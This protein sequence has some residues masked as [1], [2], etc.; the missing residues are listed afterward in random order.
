MYKLMTEKLISSLLYS[1]D[2]YIKR[3]L[4]NKIVNNLSLRSIKEIYC[5]PRLNENEKLKS[6]LIN[7]ALEKFPLNNFGHVEFDK[8]KNKNKTVKADDQKNRINKNNASGVDKQMLIA[9]TLIDNYEISNALTLLKELHQQQP[10]NRKI[11]MKIGEIYQN[12]KNIIPAH[13]FFKAAKTFYPEYGT[14]RKLS[15]EIDNGLFDNADKSIQEILS[16]PKLSLIKFLPVLNRAC[17]YFPHYREEMRRVRTEVKNTLMNVKSRKGI[18]PTDQ[19]KLALKCRWINIAN[20]IVSRN[21][22]TLKSV[23]EETVNWIDLI[24]CRIKHLKD[25]IDIASLN[26]ENHNTVGLLNGEKVILNNKKNEIKILE[27]FIPSVYFND[28]ANEKTS[29]KTVRDFYNTVIESMLELKDIII[30]PRNQWNWRYC[31][32]MYQN[33]YVLSYHTLNSLTQPGWACI[34]EST[35]ADKCS[36]DTNGFAGYSSINSIASECFHQDLSNERINKNNSFIKE[37]IAKNN[38]KYFQST[39]LIQ[40]NLHTPY[41]FLALQVTTDIVA[42]LAYID[43]LSLLSELAEYYKDKVEKVVVKRHPYCKS[44]SIENRLNELVSKNLIIISDDSIHKLIDGA[45][46]VYTVNSGV[47]LEAI[48]HNKNVITTGESDYS[49]CVS[50]AK[51]VVELHNLIKNPR[52]HLDIKDK[53]LDYYLNEYTMTANEKGKIKQKIVTSLG[54][55]NA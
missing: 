11:L 13:A 44:L 12:D 32:P 27:L 6:I 7:I 31:D 50:V 41:V 3:K 14:V 45:S 4:K 22:L 53:F 54:I 46:I 21:S 17:V 10:S 55:Y 28:P 52:C 2:S 34:Q 37:Y 15:F 18:N 47:G 39:S 26:D 8:Q 42:S 48:M 33:S 23:T 43:G 36:I 9:Q 49:N 19:A 40:N 29:Y 30:I 51:S 1:D 24:D 25:I 5:S 16:F 20:D 35:I 38:S